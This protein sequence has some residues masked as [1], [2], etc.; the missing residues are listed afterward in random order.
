MET[1]NTQTVAT[2]RIILV[3]SEF[4]CTPTVFE[5]L[6][7]N[8]IVM[9]TN[10]PPRIVID[11]ANT[12]NWIGLLSKMYAIIVPKTKIPEANIFTALSFIDFPRCKASHMK[13]P[14]NTALET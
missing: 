14:P 7:K 13:S 1:K 2:E 5:L 10:G 11:C 8:N 12:I 6:D 9:A 3:K 4:L